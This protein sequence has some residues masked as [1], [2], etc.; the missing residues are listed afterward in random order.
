[1]VFYHFL[2]QP[3]YVV[4]DRFEFCPCPHL[5]KTTGGWARKDS[6]L[7]QLLEPTNPWKPTRV[8]LS[9]FLLCAMLLIASKF[10]AWTSWL[11]KNDRRRKLA[12]PGGLYYTTWHLFAYP[13]NGGT[14]RQV[15][16]VTLG[17]E[18]RYL[19]DGGTAGAKTPNNLPPN[20]ISVRGSVQTIEHSSAHGARAGGGTSGVLSTHAEQEYTPQH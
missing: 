14:I 20:F 5:R 11:P 3:F 17:E 18:R 1:M 6:D 13:N 15:S 10:S 19:C 16:L 8:Y 4:A 9:P 7:W 2:R 12:E